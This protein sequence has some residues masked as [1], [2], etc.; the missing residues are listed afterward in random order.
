MSF[1]EEDTSYEVDPSGAL[2]G[3]SGAC[4]RVRARLTS[5]TR[6]MTVPLTTTPPTG[7]TNM[8]YLTVPGVAGVQQT[9]IAPQLSPEASRAQVCE[10]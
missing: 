5:S 9:V 3:G 10:Q 2:T 8:S 4:N 6:Q 1:S 7:P